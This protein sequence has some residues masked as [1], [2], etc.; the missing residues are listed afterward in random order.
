MLRKRDL[1]LCIIFTVLSEGTEGEYKLI[2]V[3][4]SCLHEYCYFTE[5]FIA[6]YSPMD[7][8]RFIKVKLNKQGDLTARKAVK[9]GPGY[10]I[11][12]CLYWKIY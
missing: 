8:H 9:L 1:L 11:N 6:M 12:Y 10:W 4:S 2:L 7:H 3:F 5:R